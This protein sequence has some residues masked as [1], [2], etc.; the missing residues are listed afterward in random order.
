[1]YEYPGMWLSASV[2]EGCVFFSALYYFAGVR[3]S[4]MRAQTAHF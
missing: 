2:C 3:V 1:M 4:I